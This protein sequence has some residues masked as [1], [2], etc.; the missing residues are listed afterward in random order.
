VTLT[1]TERLAL[2]D[3]HPR[4]LRLI[5]KRAYHKTTNKPLLIEGQNMQ[6]AV[7]QAASAGWIETVRPGA[8]V[9]TPAGFTLAVALRV[10]GW[11]NCEKPR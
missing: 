1:V 5:L 3:K 4:P 10:S 9:L 7:D 8:V 11:P 6:R 2:L